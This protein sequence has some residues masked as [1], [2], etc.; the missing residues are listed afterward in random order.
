MGKQISALSGQCPQTL[1]NLQ[2]HP[3]QQMSPPGIDMVAA[4]A[5]FQCSCCCRH[6]WDKEPLPPRQMP[7]NELG[8]T[9]EKISLTR[10]S[11]VAVEREISNMRNKMRAVRYKGA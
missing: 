8:R 11:I 3:V 6:L 1:Q 5:A 2:V 10:H 9:D 7:I 4:A